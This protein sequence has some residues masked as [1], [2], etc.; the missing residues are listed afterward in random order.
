MPQNEPRRESS[1]GYHVYSKYRE[2]P[3]SFYI[4][5]VLGW[6]PEKTGKALIFGGVMHDAIE[7]YYKDPARSLSLAI[8]VFQLGLAARKE[9]YE[10]EESYDEDIMMGPRFLTVWHDTWNIYDRRTYDLVE[11][12]EPYELRI[13]PNEEFL[14]TMRIDRV[15]R[16]KATKRYIVVD[17]KTTRWSIPGTFSSVECQDQMTSYLMG[18]HKV[19]P[20]WNATAAVPDIL[21]AR[22]NVTKAERP[23]EIYR[24][25]YALLQ[26]E[27]GM[28]GTIL[29][30]GQKI[31]NLAEIPNEIL[32]P[33]NGAQCSKFP[34]VY[35]I[36]CRSEINAKRMPLTF[37]LDPWLKE[38]E[39]NESSK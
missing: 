5:S 27:M 21:Y 9:E 36:F 33:R 18:L 32:F 11:V 38:E 28:Y 4:R 30:I 34:C 26:F 35:D 37:T 6:T 1:A 23:G 25:A 14:F 31:A 39:P 2:C 8:E 29:E 12:E 17:T 22:G 16:E 7:A 15:M 13:G 20:E 3:R 10:N 24:T 19:H